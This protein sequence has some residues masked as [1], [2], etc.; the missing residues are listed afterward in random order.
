[1]GLIYKLPQETINQIAAGEVVENPASVVK[2]LIENAIDAGA[3]RIEIEICGGGFLLIRVVDDGIGMAPDDALVAL[4]RHATSKIRVIADLETVKTM[5]FRGEALAAIASVSKIRVVTAQ[6]EAVQIDAEGGLLKK[7][8]ACFRTRGTTIEVRSLFF[9]VPARRKF[10]K[11]ASASASEVHR[12]VMVMS[13]SHPEIAFRFVNNDIEVLKLSACK[14]GTVAERLRQRTA[15]LFGDNYSRDSIILESHEGEPKFQ[16]ILGSPQQHR[17]NRLGQYFFINRR[18]IV[19][20]PLAFAI[21]DA[22]GTRINKDRYPIFVLH[23]E[24]DPKQVDVNVHPQKREVRFQNQEQ[25]QHHLRKAVSEAL[26]PQPKIDNAVF[27]MPAQK[28]S[29]TPSLIFREELHSEEVLSPVLFNSAPQLMELFGHF[30]FLRG[31]KIVVV[32]LKAGFAKQIEELVTKNDQPLASQRL[33]LPITIGLS[34]DET[35]QLNCRLAMVHHL[36]F[37]LH[38]AGKS[39]WLINA[40]PE[41][42]ASKDAGDILRRVLEGDMLYKFCAEVVSRKKQFMLQEALSIWK[43]LSSS[44]RKALAYKGQPIVLEWSNDDLAQLFRLRKTS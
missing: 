23:L 44:D 32:D 8:T 7:Q 39:Q 19:S 41:C 6:N 22:Y 18:A 1:M 37:E 31:E 15:D 5:G 33:L 42:I 38:L 25:L 43:Y 28:D 3:K 13:L 40:I 2:E 36:G 34:P 30:L 29:F 14:T 35:A 10:Q 9:N 12:L 24:I 27:C 4:E 20:P 21:K 26:D 11:S 16:A 17:P